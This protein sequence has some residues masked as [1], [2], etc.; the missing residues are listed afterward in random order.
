MDFLCFGGVLVC[1][2]YGVM[3]ADPKKIIR[4]SHIGEGMLVADL[5]V[6][7]G[8]HAMLAARAVGAS[9]IVYAFDIQKELL[10]KVRREAEKEGL[11]NVHVVWTDLDEP[12]GTRLADGILDVALV[13]NVLFQI[14]KKEQFMQ[15]V[16]R[17]VKNGGKVVVV[18]WQEASG[19]IGPHT[20]HLFGK[21]AARTLAES[22]GLTFEEDIDAGSHHY[23]MIFRKKK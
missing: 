7:S 18:D 14:E 9:G 3:F 10:N 5:G 12:R 2:A 1:Y 19:G 17:I 13:T 16:A 20:D 4:Q 21:H 11:T 8:A 22:V 23:G 15:E 6:G